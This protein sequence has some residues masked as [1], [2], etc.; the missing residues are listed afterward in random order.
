MLLSC[1]WISYSRNDSDF[2]NANENM[3]IT[4]NSKLN[5]SST[6]LTPPARL[7]HKSKIHVIHMSPRSAAH[8]AAMS[9]QA[10]RGSLARG[11]HYAAQRVRHRYVSLA[12]SLAVVQPA[13]RCAARTATLCPVLRHRGQGG[14][15]DVPQATG[16]WPGTVSDVEAPCVQRLAAATRGM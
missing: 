11:Q 9:H 12:T 15:P 7:L 6:S 2:W 5:S 3:F 8:G 10:H 16:H 1:S 13:L 14:A 4:Q